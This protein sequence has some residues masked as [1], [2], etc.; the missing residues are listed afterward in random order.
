MTDYSSASNV[1]SSSEM[2]SHL[3]DLEHEGPPLA[4]TTSSTDLSDSSDP[5]LLSEMEM[6]EQSIQIHVN[7]A[8]DLFRKKTDYD[9]TQLRQVK[10]LAQFIY[11]R[12]N[13]ADEFDE[14][15]HLFDKWVLEHQA[16]ASQYATMMISQFIEKYAN[17]KSIGHTIGRYVNA[18]KRFHVNISERVR[19]QISILKKEQ[20][21]PDSHR[22]NNELSKLKERQ[23]ERLDSKYESMIKYMK[24][25]SPSSFRDL[26]LETLESCQNDLSNATL[27]DI[28]VLSRKTDEELR[29][30]LLCSRSFVS[31]SRATGMRSINALNLTLDSF[32]LTDHGLLVERAERKCGSLRNVEKTVFCQLVHHKDPEL[33]P[34][35]HLSEFLDGCNMGQ[36]DYIY[37]F[38]FQNPSNTNVKSA[39]ISVTRRFTAVLHTVAKAVGLDG[40]GGTQDKKLHIFRVMCENTLIAHNATA[41][42]RQLHIGWTNSTQARSYTARKHAAIMTRTSFLL[43][44]RKDHTDPPHELWSDFTACNN[45]WYEIVR[46]FRNNKRRGDS[47]EEHLPTAKISK[48]NETPTAEMLQSLVK[49]LKLQAKNLDFPQICLNHWCEVAELIDEGSV[50]GNFCLKQSDADGKALIQILILALLAKMKSQLLEQRSVNTSWLQYAEKLKKSDSIQFDTRN[51]LLFKKYFD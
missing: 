2:G 8:V 45:W 42:E 34:I 15:F 32:T 10:H 20:W 18:W 50:R 24:S 40:L 9:V 51:W 19:D 1:L 23:F 38:G 17:S 36:S 26:L 16:K 35:I 7:T 49:H 13:I 27:R 3:S 28:G 31:L 22:R 47:L 37:R 43:A 21:N 29:L 12:E 41:L 30:I 44:N 39:N 25:V 4:M 14:W 11:K 5:Q 46:L 33:D 48:V 6:A